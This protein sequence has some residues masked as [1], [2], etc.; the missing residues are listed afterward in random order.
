MLHIYASVLGVFHTYVGVSSLYLHTFAMTTHVFPSFLVFCK[1]F[2]CML[3]VFQLFWIFVMSVLSEYCKSRLGVAHIAMRVRSGA[4]G[5]EQ[6]L[7]VVWWREPRVG[8]RNAS[9]T[10]ACWPKHRKRSAALQEKRRTNP[11]YL[12][13]GANSY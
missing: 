11:F 10:G 2:R 7:C 12:H 5:H 8:T 3:Q 1:C 6:A 13:A 4:R 9:S